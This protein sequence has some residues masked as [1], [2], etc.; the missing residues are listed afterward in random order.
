MKFEL[1]S[2][3]EVAA[4]VT[5][6][7]QRN[8]YEI[9]LQAPQESQESLEIIRQEICKAWVDAT[10]KRSERSIKIKIS[11]V[12]VCPSCHNPSCR[13]DPLH[14]QCYLPIV[15]HCKR[16]GNTPDS[17]SPFFE[18]RDAVDKVRNF[19]VHVDSVFRLY[20][21]SS[22]YLST[23]SQDYNTSLINYFYVYYSK[24]IFMYMLPIMEEVV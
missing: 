2:N 15:G 24:F 12:V 16:C 3:D 5:L 4:T 7:Y 11:F 9:Q 8:M 19:L 1:K 14:I 21:C 6:V 20:T 13:C 23:K 10:G 18:W 22:K 17:S